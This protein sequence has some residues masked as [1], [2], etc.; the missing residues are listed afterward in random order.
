MAL[1]NSYLK[2]NGEAI[3]NPTSLQIADTN[4]EQTKQSED[5]HDLVTITRLCKRT[6]TFAFTATSTGYAKIKTWCAMASVTLTW[7]S[8]S[9]VGRL[10]LTGSQLMPDSEYCARTDGIWTLNV[11]FTEI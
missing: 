8:E 2:I 11:T 5:G 4:I 6:F 9:I 1:G 10:R 3:F 7:N